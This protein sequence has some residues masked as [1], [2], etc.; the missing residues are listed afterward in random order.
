MPATTLE[1]YRPGPTSRRRRTEEEMSEIK[2]HAERDPLRYVIII[3]DD[4]NNKFR[5]FILI[6]F[7]SLAR[8][9]ETGD[10]SGGALR[11]CWAAREMLLIFVQFPADADC[12]SA[13]LFCDS[14][15]VSLFGAV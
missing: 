15:C 3:I 8:A 2:V 1:S 11:K 4:S 10:S 9:R 5:L 12:G 6:F 7:A 13:S 14:W